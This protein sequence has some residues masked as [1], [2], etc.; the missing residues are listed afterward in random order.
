MKIDLYGYQYD[1]HIETYAIPDS[2]LASFV[3]PG[4][5]RGWELTGH[6]A[7]AA[8]LKPKETN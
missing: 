2:S 8:D 3:F 6:G 5:L 7:F 4:L 1:I